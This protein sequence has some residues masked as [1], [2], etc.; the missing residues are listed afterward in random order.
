MTMMT[1]S[2]KLPFPEEDLTV[3]SKNKDDRRPH[4]CHA[5]VLKE[6]YNSFLEEELQLINNS[7]K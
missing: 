2:L 5:A 6:M 1:T 4:L 3:K 7:N